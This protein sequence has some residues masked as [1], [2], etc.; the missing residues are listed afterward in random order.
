MPVLLPRCLHLLMILSWL[1]PLFS[2]CFIV[3]LHIFHI[4]VCHS[5]NF[6]YQKWYIMPA[7]YFNYQIHNKLCPVVASVTV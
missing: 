3:D 7:S 6:G 1:S 5:L 4:F 2:Y